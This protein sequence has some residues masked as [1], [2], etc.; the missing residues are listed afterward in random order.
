M[1]DTQQSDAFLGVQ[2]S[3][4]GRQWQVRVSED[5]HVLALQQALNLP[6]VVARVLIGRGIGLDEAPSFLAPRL[7]DLLPDPSSFKDMDKT[8][9]RLA[10]AIET[11]EGIAI[12]GDYDVDGATSSA[13]FLS[14][15]KAIGVDALVHIP[16]REKEG[17]GPNSVALTSLR[18]RGAKVCLTVDC[19]TT[20]FEAL[21]VGHEQGLDVIVVDHHMPDAALPPAFA[22]VNPNRLDEP[23]TYGNLAAVG[24][25][26]LVLVALNRT[27]R[28]RGLFTPERPEPDLMSLLDMVALG[29][30]A[31]VVSLTGLNRALV[32]QGL[33]VMGQWRRPGLRA[34]ATVSGLSEAPSAY[35]LGYQLGP[36]INAGGRVGQSDLGVRLLTSDTDDQARQVAQS[37]DQYNQ[38]RKTIEA[39]VQQHAEHLMADTV[40]NTG[41]PPVVMLAEEGWHAGIIGIVAAR[42]KESYNRPTLIGARKE[43]LIKA[44]GRSIKGV[45]L[46]AAVI[47]AHQANL[48]IAGGG[49]AMAA[50]LTCTEENWARLKEFLSDRIAQQLAQLP[51]VPT[52]SV[53]GALSVGGATAQLVETLEQVGP[54]GSGNPEPRLVIQNARVS[55]ADVVGQNHVKCTLEDGSGRRL[56]AIAFRALGTP[57]GD[58]LMQRRPSTLHVAG[59]LRADHWRGEKRVQLQIDDAAVS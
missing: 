20:A 13:L 30:V 27:L 19:G 54:F 24:V 38:D 48:L 14:Y 32:A 58:L 53:D 22:V 8:A 39:E 50:G 46:G 26:F 17:Y 56:Q 37:L 29:T 59:K 5:R 55:Y 43:G 25:S 21:T 7:K 11:G 3:A 51:P 4:L 45:D 36:R 9:N 15:L 52:L 34:L 49:H 33:K 31:D 1:S 57:L 2:Q 40:A 41:V 23:Q 42:I 35:H 6:E 10:D 28:A 12:F 16:D 47:A 44:S 18:Q